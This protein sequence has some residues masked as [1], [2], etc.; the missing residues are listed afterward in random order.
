M[1]VLFLK[2]RNRRG[3]AARARGGEE[4]IKGTLFALKRGECATIVRVSVEGGALARLTAL[5]V[6][7]GARVEALAFSLFHGSI[8]ISCSSVRVSIRRALAEKI[9]VAM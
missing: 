7:K 8:L 5:G 6:V 4:K 3:R 9:E 2:K 1:T